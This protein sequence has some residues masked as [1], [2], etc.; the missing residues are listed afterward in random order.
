MPPP[1]GPPPKLVFAPVG[2]P[3]YVEVR[4]PL[5]PDGL[6]WFRRLV[7]FTPTLRLKRC[8]VK[9]LPPRP[10]RPPAA[11]IRIPPPPPPPR[12]PPPP[13]P[14]PKPPPPPRPPP[15]PPG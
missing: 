10:P 13:P 12:A 5:K 4:L 2:R 15:P 1:P 3:K 6:K 7:T 9:V 14:P 11:P 8:S